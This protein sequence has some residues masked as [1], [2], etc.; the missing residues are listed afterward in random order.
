MLD[1]I[2]SFLMALMLVSISFAMSGEAQDFEGTFL[3]SST[4]PYGV[5]PFRYEG[6]RFISITFKT[7]PEV[8]RALVPP[9]AG[10]RFKQ[11]NECS[12]WSAEDYRT[13]AC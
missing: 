4:L 10:G 1:K 9:T 11:Y 3:C 6:S 2:R 13:E 5:P 12:H 8:I 7:S